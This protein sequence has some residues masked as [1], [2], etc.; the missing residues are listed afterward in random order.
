ML[1]S[2]YIMN[3]AGS[4]LYQKDFAEIPKMASNERI[5]LA[6]LFHGLCAFAGQLSPGA[7][8][9]GIEMLETDTFQ[10]QRLQTLTGTW[11]PAPTAATSRPPSRG[12][13]AK[14]GV[15]RTV[16][17]TVTTRPLVRLRELTDRPVPSPPVG[18]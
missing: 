6:G 8:N 5:M 3:K 10:L 17:P 15:V 7:D 11:R 16:A 14:Q 1:F 12:P 2:M 9:S 4:L 13:A 18:E